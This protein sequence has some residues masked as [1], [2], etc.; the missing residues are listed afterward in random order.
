M[1]TDRFV[2][3]PAS[4]GAQWVIMLIIVAMLAAGSAAVGAPVPV[5]VATLAILVGMAALFAFILRSSRGAPVTLGEAGIG[6]KSVLY[7]RTI[8][9]SELDVSRAQMVDL[10]ARSEFRPRLRANGI[11]LP[12]YQ[13]GWFTLANGKDGL[14]FVS[15]RTRVVAI[16]ARS[17]TLLLSIAEPEAFLESA[18]RWSGAERSPQ[19]S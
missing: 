12:G 2:V 19:P 7:G 17:Y 3:T 9:W 10:S 8:P 1:R 4:R 18:R 6:I 13:A 16:P 15:D 5:T 14:L 11:G